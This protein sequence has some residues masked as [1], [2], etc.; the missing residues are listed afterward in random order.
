MAGNLINVISYN[1]DEHIFYRIT[2]TPKHDYRFTEEKKQNDIRLDES[3]SR[4]RRRLVD[5]ALCNSW[6]H[7]CT[8]TFSDT[9]YNYL[10]CKRKLVQ[11]FNNYK[12]RV[13]KDFKYLVVPE[14]HK[15]GAFHF[16]GFV[17]GVTDFTV[18]EKVMKRLSDGMYIEVNNTKKY[19]RWDSYK[20]GWF[21][22]SPVKNHYATALYC[23]KYVTKDLVNHS[24]A[25]PKGS[26]LILHSQGLITP[27][28]IN[29]FECEKS[30]FK[31][32][33]DKLVICS[34]GLVFYDNL[35][36]SDL[37]KVLHELRS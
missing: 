7:F 16:H 4:T 22:A 15:D 19:L 8:F 35:S 6:S 27:T 14:C 29:T 1:C 3:L 32:I 23:S 33:D 21:N 18:P 20:L 37:S 5:L 31:S 11:F 34:S 30:V 28:V 26:Q 36:A 2:V 12:K 10:E 25:F 17:S 9:R 13:S 24:H